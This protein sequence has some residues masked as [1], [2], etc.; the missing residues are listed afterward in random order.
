MRVRTMNDLCSSLECIACESPGDVRCSTTST[1]I[2][3]SVSKLEPLFRPICFD[4]PLYRIIHST[5]FLHLQPQPQTL[6]VV[7]ETLQR[8]YSLQVVRNAPQSDVEKLLERL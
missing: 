7:V 3:A 5:L 6:G 1:W 8:L 4:Y 2:S